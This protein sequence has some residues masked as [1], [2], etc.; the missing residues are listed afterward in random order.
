MYRCS[1]AKAAGGP[2]KSKQ[3]DESRVT[4]RKK[5]AIDA[6][7]ISMDSTARAQL[8][9]FFSIGRE[10]KEQERT[11]SVVMDTDESSNQIPP[12]STGPP[13]LWVVY[14]MDVLNKYYSFPSGE[15]GQNTSPSKCIAVTTD[16]ST[17]A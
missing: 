7:E 3:D 17:M 11:H 5:I 14:Q 4:V 16:S 2:L 15:S 10:K 13:A 12:L 8:Y 9:M 1:E 6:K